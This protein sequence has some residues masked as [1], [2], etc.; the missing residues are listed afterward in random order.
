MKRRLTGHVWL[1][2]ACSRWRHNKKDVGF[3]IQERVLST[4][5]AFLFVPYGVFRH[6]Q[7]NLI[8]S[9]YFFAQLPCCYCILYSLWKELNTH[10]GEANLVSFDILVNRSFVFARE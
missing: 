6:F 8:R 5:P 3:V 10:E 2:S 4:V 9:L 7:T 1:W